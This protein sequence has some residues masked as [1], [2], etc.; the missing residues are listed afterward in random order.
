MNYLLILALIWLLAEFS[1]VFRDRIQG[2]GRPEKDKGTRNYN[3]LSIM[4]SIVLSIIIVQ[5]TDFPFV[6][7]NIAFCIWLGAIVIAIGILIRVWA[8]ITL[9]NA[10][11]TTIETDKGQ[12]VVTS[13]PYKLIR[14][15]SYSGAMLICLG[16]GIAFQNWL[17]LGV[18]IVLP[19]IAIL[20][21]I[22]Y[23]EA[24]MV[25]E[26]GEEYRDYQRKTKKLIPY[27]W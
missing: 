23:E 24:A 1:L 14:H 15:P 16:Y 27:I 3:L 13:G 19:P 11:R 7:H 20:Y 9:G 17:A 25:D 8:I 10:F 5:K 4:I 18:L 21:R 6:G 2:K 12:K 26:L 22:P